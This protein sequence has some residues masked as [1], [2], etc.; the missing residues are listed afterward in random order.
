MALACEDCHFSPIDPCKVIDEYELLSS[1]GRCPH[2]RK[3]QSKHNDVEL[4]AVMD[5]NCHTIQPGLNSICERQE[6]FTLRLIAKKETQ[7]I[8][9]GPQAITF[10]LKSFRQDLLRFAGGQPQG[11]YSVLDLKDKPLWISP[12]YPKAQTTNCAASSVLVEK[13]P[14]HE[15]RHVPVEVEVLVWKKYPQNSF[16]PQRVVLSVAVPPD[17]EDYHP[18]SG[19]NSE[20]NKGTNQFRDSSE[21]VGTK[22]RAEEP[23]HLARQRRKQKIRKGGITVDPITIITLISSGLKLVDSFREMAIKFRGQVPAPPSAKAEQVGSA[24]EVRK[25]G[26]VIQKVEATQLR[27]DE[28]D[29]PRYEALK[30]RLQKNWTIYNDLFTNEAGSSLQEGAR[31]RADMASLQENLCRDF[32]EMVSLYERTLGMN[33]PDHYQ[34]F[35]VCQS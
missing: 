20:A 22:R 31:I 1:A 2:I 11:I 10:Q 30:K 33:L 3:A 6:S 7:K 32:R 21:P 35:E 9:P 5:S 17:S 34:L 24:L 14:E 27:M 16:N 8:M 4:Y 26:Q 19:H 25:G 28:W 29:A 23:R 15:L 13:Y 18:S 12:S